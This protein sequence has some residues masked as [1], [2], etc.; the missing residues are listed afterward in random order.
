MNSEAMA[1]WLL[2]GYFII[3][4]GLVVMRLAT[5]GF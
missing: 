4:A 2:Y 3:G 1:E 5:V